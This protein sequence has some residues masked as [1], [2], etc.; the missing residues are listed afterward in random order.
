M[1]TV[2]V[3][4]NIWDEIVSLPA[5]STQ[6]VSYNFTVDPLLVSCTLYRLIAESRA[7][8]KIDHLNWSLT[9]H[10]DKIIA[11][12]TDQDRVFAESLVSY[13]KSKLIMAKLRGDH[14]TKFKTDLLK[15]L[16]DSPT[17]VT[18]KFVGMI[19][20]L[21]YFYQ[22]DMQLIEIFDGAK[23]DLEKV[24]NHLERQD[25]NL[26]FISKADTGQKKARHYEYWFKDENNLRFLV[27][28]EKYNPIR[29]LWEKA[30][31]NGDL[32]INSIF[33]KKR[34]DNLE[35]YTAKG[36]HISV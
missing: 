8:D 31:Q 2:S 12:I 24:P 22:Y 36:W 10:T 18:S 9:D 4:S 29:P 20:K 1:R 17:S 32:S 19:Y 30:I 5:D 27:E 35:F 7:K 15:Y 34:R 25:I 16:T 14:F 23:S 33:E 11:K 28:V 26:S 6:E 13:Y 21:P 3:T